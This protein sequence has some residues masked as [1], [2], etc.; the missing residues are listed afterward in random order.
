MDLL[1]VSPTLEERYWEKVDKRGPDDCWLWKNSTDGTKGYGRVYV[2]Y[3]NGKKR[4]LQ[5]HRVAWFLRHGV[6][7]DLWVLH[8]CDNPPCQNPEHLF[9]GTNQDNVDDK[10]RKGRGGYT[11]TPGEKHYKARLTEEDVLHIR[12]L[13]FAEIRIADIAQR[14]DIHYGHVRSILTEHSWKTAGVSAA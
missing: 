3:L 14:Y 11:G 5:S 1:G 6:F 12:A 10:M 9:L 2:G 4:N 7:P 13:Q 8:R